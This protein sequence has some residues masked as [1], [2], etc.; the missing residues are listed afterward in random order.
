[1]AVSM[2]ALVG[3]TFGTMVVPQR[4][5]RRCQRRPELAYFGSKHVMMS[6]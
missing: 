6:Y 4:K 2:H 1:M 3:A 5:Y